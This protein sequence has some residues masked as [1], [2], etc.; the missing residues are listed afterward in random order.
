LQLHLP[1]VARSWLRKLEK[2]TIG[3]GKSSQSSSRVTSS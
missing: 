2:E 1:G 3:T